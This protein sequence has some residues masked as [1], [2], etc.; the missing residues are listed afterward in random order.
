MEVNFI[1]VLIAGVIAMVVGFVWYG[2]LFG[3]KWMDL[4]GATPESMSSE[5]VQKQMMPT[6]VLQFVLAL[7]EAFI[8][9]HY[10]KGWE[11][12]SGIE[13][14]VWIW[15]GFVVPALASTVMWTTDSSKI[16]MER[17]AIQAGYHFLLL[18]IWGYMFQMWA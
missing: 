17:F 6:Y 14:A 2:P 13:S 11:E 9:Y 18:L 5:E 1:A 15:L 4:I 10:V 7:L 8:F 12:A 16:K 3:K